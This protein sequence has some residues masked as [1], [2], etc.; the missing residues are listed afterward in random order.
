MVSFAVKMTDRNC[1]IIHYQCIL[2]II[3]T[4]MCLIPNV[5][6]E[7]DSNTSSPSGDDVKSL[8]KSVGSRG[9]VRR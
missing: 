2:V 1:S 7:L 3:N 9:E 4:I 5:T 8:P 6:P